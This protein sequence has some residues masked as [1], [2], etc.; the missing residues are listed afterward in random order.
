MEML[1]FNFVQIIVIYHNTSQ[2]KENL[3][4]IK[5]K[6]YQ[7]QKVVSCFANLQILKNI[8]QCLQEC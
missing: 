3:T 1:W 5:T 4:Q 6:L 8:S 2:I 7:A